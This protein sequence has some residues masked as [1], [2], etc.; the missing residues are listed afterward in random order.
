MDKLL[1]RAKIAIMSARPE[2]AIEIIEK[3]SEVAGASVLKAEDKEEIRA[4]VADLLRLA[5]ASL[6]GA[7]SAA[8]R[9]AEIV[10]T[11]GSLQVYNEDGQRQETLVVAHQPRRF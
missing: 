8:E 7:K 11:A 9:I 2:E 6:R 5:E 1:A 10:R 3:F 4:S